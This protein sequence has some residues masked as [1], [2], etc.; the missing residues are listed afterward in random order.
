MTERVYVSKRELTWR[1]SFIVLMS[2][3]YNLI[4]GGVYKSLG[5]LLPTLR[6]Q[7][8]THTWVIG[9]VA[10]L[11]SCGTALSGRLWVP[12][13]EQVMLKLEIYVCWL[14]EHNAFPHLVLFKK[15]KK[16]N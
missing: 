3:T 16:K 8:T 15:K 12:S 6:D 13:F 10:S 7:F 1:G 11:M 5:V 14:T 4:W 9:I 2:I